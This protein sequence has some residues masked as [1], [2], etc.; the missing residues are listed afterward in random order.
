MSGAIKT[1]R[2]KFR[3]RNQNKN[4]GTQ[5]NCQGNPRSFVFGVLDCSSTRSRVFNIALKMKACRGAKRKNVNCF[6]SELTAVLWPVQSK[7][8]CCIKVLGPF[9]K[10][11]QRAALVHTLDHHSK[12]NSQNQIQSWSTWVTPAHLSLSQGHP[13]SP[14]TS[15]KTVL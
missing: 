1:N 2:N 9:N 11:V 12:I 8:K 14:S 13:I 3:W 10:S 4:C 6:E 7:T 15:P 5:R